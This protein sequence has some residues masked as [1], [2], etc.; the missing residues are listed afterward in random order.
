VSTP[1]TTPDKSH[2]LFF[3]WW[4][5]L[6]G[7]IN[8]GLFSLLYYQSFGG[9]LV[10]FRDDFGWSRSSLSAAYSF[11]RA[12]SSI[13]AP[14]QG[15]LL[16]RVSPRSMMRV[17]IIIMAGGFFYLSHVDSLIA[18]YLAYLFIA[19]G[20]SLAGFLTINITVA[21][22]F[23]R[24]RTR[25]LALTMMGGT[26]GGLAAPLLAWSLEQF[27][28]RDTATATGVLLLVAGL[29]IAQLLRHEPEAY[30]Y[31]PD[32]DLREL[33]PEGTASDFKTADPKLDGFTLKEAVATQAFWF[34]ALGNGVA[35]LSI[36]VINSQLIIHMVDLLNMSITTA[37]SVVWPVMLVSQL[38]FQVVGGLLGDRFNKQA[39]AAIAMVGHGGAMFMLAG[40]SALWLII[41]AMMLHGSAWGLRG[42]IMTAIR[43]DY[44]GRRSLGAIM[45]FGTTFAMIGSTVGPIFAGYILDN[46][47]SY[48]PAF[49][50]IAVIVTAGSLFFV[51]ASK[52]KDPARLRR[53]GAAALSR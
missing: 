49:S 2:R 14:I 15:W 34:L 12:E 35:L 39:I 30:G 18:Y 32:G 40:S 10:L 41:L 3:G 48:R 38:I 46:Y 21:R 31:L 33:G 7:A 53:Q 8:Q 45:G 20:S 25:A 51:F 43:A 9:Y 23:V 29:P 4:I 28:W 47:D 36:S 11:A 6:G 42:P 22:W 50:I 1:T 37:T 13:V 52:P 17:G 16:D 44:F 26:I 24:N 19:I 27:G 5:V